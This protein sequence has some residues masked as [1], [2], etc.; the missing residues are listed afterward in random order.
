MW[1]LFLWISNSYWLSTQWWRGMIVKQF[2]EN[3]VLPPVCN[4]LEQSLGN[5]R[6]RTLSPEHRLLAWN[7]PES[8]YSILSQGASLKELP[9]NIFCNVSFSLIWKRTRKKVLKSI[10]FKVSKGGLPF[11]CVC[12]EISYCCQLKQSVVL[13][14]KLNFLPQLKELVLI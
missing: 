6:K 7:N 4:F 5:V 1:N 9:E 14:Y 11:I 3:I 2:K 8:Q 12:L 10:K 13:V